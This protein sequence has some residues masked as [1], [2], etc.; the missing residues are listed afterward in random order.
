M[1]ET[2]SIEMLWISGTNPAVSLPELERIRSILTEG[3]MFVI[4]Q[5]IFPTETTALADVIL[6]AAGWG[7][8]T[9]CYTNVDRT[10]HLSN[11]AVEPPGEARSD[12]DIWVDYATRMNFT[13]KDGKPLVHWKTASEAFE[14]WRKMSKDTLCDY[15]GYVYTVLY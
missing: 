6:P 11:K 14:V 9:G 7:E 12:L 5:D 4:A 10:V 1:M 2:G 15:S 3:N 8:K 13:D